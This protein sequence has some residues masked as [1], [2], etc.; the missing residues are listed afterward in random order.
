VDTKSN[1]RI[2]GTGLGL[3]IT[4]M[5][6]E[7]MDGGVT[8][9]S[10]YGKG[11]LFSIRIR[12]GY[13][14]ESIIGK[15]VAE[16]LARFHF[17]AHRRSSNEKL[18]RNYMPYARV[19]VVDDVL[20]NLD[21]A[22]GM[23]KP[24]GMTVDCDT[25]GQKAVD[26]VREAK[27]KYDAIFMDHMMPDIDGI[28][29]VRI[30]RNE[31]NA[32]YAKTVPIIAFTANAIVG[33]D[34]LF[35]KNGFQAFLSKPIDIMRLDIILNQWV[36]N[37][38]LEKEQPPRQVIRP[39]IP[40]DPLPFKLKI[41][42]VDFARGLRLFGNKESY[43]DVIRSFIIHT[44]AMLDV[45]REPKPLPVYGATAHSIKGAAYGICADSVGKKAEQLEHAAKSGDSD[46]IGSHNASFIALTEKLLQDLSVSLN[47]IDGEQS[48]PKKPAPDKALLARVLEACARYDI[49]E[50]DGLITELEQ[51]NYES[52]SDLIPWL[53][54][55][56]R[57]SEFEDIG[58]ELTKI[59]SDSK[60]A[61]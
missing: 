31:I 41:E 29:A 37:R 33:N 25:S 8:V 47:T 48:K 20:V 45:I 51:Y 30:I 32:E 18:I 42:G 38:E 57:K 1:R 40:D 23:L 49:D 10:E 59:L 24:Y 13:V 17:T 39:E 19:L 21:V 53:R 27:V 16:N 61:D 34:E 58:G 44:P 15:E 12:Q 9:E 56:S 52:Q 55:Q 22:K 28:E 11:S 3:S 54:E 50:L 5:L 43:L 60:M 36:R 2:E 14:N 26:L 6:V 35:L 4:K 46:F 7:L